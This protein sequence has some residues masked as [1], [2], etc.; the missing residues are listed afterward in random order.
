MGKLIG[1]IKFTGRVG[2]LSFY[3]HK[4][5]GEIRVRTL[6]GP[7]AEQVKYGENF[8]NTRGYN[9]EFGRASGTG[10]L[11]RHAIP[12]ITKYCRSSDLN[13]DLV[14]VLKAIIQTDPVNK[15]GERIV[16]AGKVEL[17]EDFQWN[18]AL[19]LEAAL[20][21]ECV[22][23]IDPNSGKMQVIVAS[24]NA[25]EAI[26]APENATHY[27]IS[28]AGIAIHP[29]EK[30]KK[31]EIVSGPVSPVNGGAVKALTLDVALNA[32]GY[33]LVLLGLGITFFETVNS[34]KKPLPGGAFQVLKAQK[35]T[36]EEKKKPE[37]KAE[38]AEPILQQSLFV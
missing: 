19:P 26:K 24:F 14:S 25:R 20:N 21:T 18:K 7:S 8:G 35:L 15:L 22:G 9:K 29:E 23:L 34:K 36:V 30:T 17:L 2:N 13:T 28:A 4:E 10:K 38:P 32:S 33:S 12:A 5:S 16:S 6:G 31:A 3:E 27:Q 1:D 37:K 11:L